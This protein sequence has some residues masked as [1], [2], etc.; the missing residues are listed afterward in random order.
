MNILKILI[1]GL[2]ISIIPCLACNS[3]S[4][5]KETSHKNSNAKLI[6]VY[7]F[8]YNDFENKRSTDLNE[9]DL[10]NHT[11]AKKYYV[12][13]DY[14]KAILHF[15]KE[16][17]PSPI[18]TLYI[19]NCYLDL[20]EYPKAMSELQTILNTESEDIVHHKDWYLVLCHLGLK[21]KDKASLLLNEIKVNKTHLFN[22][23]SI[24]LLRMIGNH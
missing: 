23:K 2:T 24:E 5:K 10:K 9:Q 16:S 7:R 15:Q 22:I 12:D 21:N 4:D 1:L 8:K 20:N 17:A 6:N 13:G 19:A 14:Q 18:T 3:T 11:E